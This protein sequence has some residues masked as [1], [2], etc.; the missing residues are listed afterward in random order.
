MTKSE[1]KDDSDPRTD[2]AAAD[3]AKH[4]KALAEQRKNPGKSGR[5]S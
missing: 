2:G 3:K 5:E 4:D 1:S